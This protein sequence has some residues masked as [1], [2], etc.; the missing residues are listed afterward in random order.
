[1]EQLKH[2]T[3]CHISGEDQTL[4]LIFGQI[5]DLTYPVDR[6]SSQD[7]YQINYLAVHREY[8]AISANNL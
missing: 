6:L 2:K 7:G 5:S 4:N 8:P 1:M 3:G